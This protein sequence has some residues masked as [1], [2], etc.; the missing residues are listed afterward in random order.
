MSGMK[1]TL[2]FAAKGLGLGLFAGGIT[3]ALTDQIFGYI[4]FPV[5]A[6]VGFYARRQK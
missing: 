1:P 6:F 4:L 3:H 5:I 2:A